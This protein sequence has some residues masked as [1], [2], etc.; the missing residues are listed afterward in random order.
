MVWREV[1]CGVAWAG[2]GVVTGGACGEGVYGMWRGV[3]GVWRE[4]WR[5]KGGGVARGVACGVAEKFLPVLAR[6]VYAWVI[7]GWVCLSCLCRRRVCACVCFIVIYHPT[8]HTCVC[9]S[10]GAPTVPR[11][12]GSPGHRGLGCVGAVL[13]ADLVAHRRSC[14]RA[15]LSTLPSSVCCSEPPVIVPEM[16]DSKLQRGIH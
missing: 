4:G 16:A 10:S 1:G 14:W 8:T 6:P 2:V 13:D 9:V 11:H 15:T 12:M 5:G 7:C 3:C